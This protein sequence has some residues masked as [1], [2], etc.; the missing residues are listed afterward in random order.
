MRLLAVVTSENGMKQGTHL[1]VNGNAAA[2]DHPE[3]ELSRRR[4]P[5]LNFDL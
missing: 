1:S 2:D 3:P 5:A 4:R